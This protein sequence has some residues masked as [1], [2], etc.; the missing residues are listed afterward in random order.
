M[1]FQEN[2][3]YQSVL[4]GFFGFF[5]LALILLPKLSA[6]AEVSFVPGITLATEYED[7]IDFNSNSNDAKDDFA[8]SAIPNARLRYRTERLDLNGNAS[9]DFKKY[10]NDTEYD[11]TNQLYAIRT[12]YQAQPRWTLS[13]NYSFTRDETIDSHFEE[14]GQLFERKRE[15]RHDAMVGVQFSLTELTDIGSFVSYRKSDFSGSDSTDYDRYTIE[16]PCFKKLQNQ[17]D[18]IGITPAY[19]HY[20]SD[21]NEEAND[22]RLSF[23]WEHFLNETLTFSMNVGPRYTTVKDVNGDEDS[24][25]GGV[26]AI[27][28]NK[29]GE[30]FTG[31]IRYSRD[32]RSTTTGEIINVDRLYVFV[33]KLITERFGARFKGNA[34]YSDRENKND[35]NDKTVS[36]EL[37]PALYY[38]I[39][40]NY[41][42]ELSY[43]YRKE[44]E[45]SESGNPST[46]SN[47]VMLSFNF[48]FPKLW[49]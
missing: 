32:L 46:Q 11:R 16:F 3:I 31:D 4:F 20:N 22:Y 15:Q 42:A 30:T 41:F 40:E 1:P 43:N 39:T 21:D 44:H 9:L 25:Y 38:M 37:V 10:L 12:K 49:D 29:K 45:L 5:C 34:Y 28:L 47:S 27:G 23:D 48:T 24:N 33:D 18:S 6:A 8:G 7:N 17:I 26:G 35:P 2:K 14:T 36:F 13:G 19:S